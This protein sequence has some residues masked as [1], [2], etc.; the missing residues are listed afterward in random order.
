[1]AAKTEKEIGIKMF[2]E[3]DSAA[4]EAQFQ[5]LIKDLEAS[6][7]GM[8]Q[9]MGA[10]FGGSFRPQQVFDPAQNRLNLARVLSRATELQKGSFT[11]GGIGQAIEDEVSQGLKDVL[12]GPRG[13]E[14]FGKK[15]A[16]DMGDAFDEMLTGDPV[17]QDD[18]LEF[19][20]SYD[21]IR[22]FAS[23]NIGILDE[24]IE[25]IGPIG[26]EIEAAFQTD[27]DNEQFIE[28]ADALDYLGDVSGIKLTPTLQRLTDE[29][30]D[31]GNEFRAVE[32]K[33][34][35]GRIGTEIGGLAKPLAN[36][37]QS[38]AKFARRIGFMA[39]IMS[40]TAQRIV[41]AVKSIGMQIVDLIKKFGS[42]DSAGK[43][44]S[45]ALGKLALG[46][47]ATEERINDLTGAF[48]SLMEHIPAVQGALGLLESAWFQLGAA[49]VEG[50]VDPDEALGPFER[51]AKEIYR[52][53]TDNTLLNAISSAI[54]NFL[55]PIADAL[56]EI[57]QVQIAAFAENLQYVASILGQFAAGVIQGFVDFVNW[58]GK[59]VEHNPELESLAFWLGKILVPVMLLGVPVTLIASA[60]NILGTAIGSLLSPLAKTVGILT[61]ASEGASILSK[62]ITFLQGK[63]LW[64]IPGW[65]L[66]AMAIATVTAYGADL[67]GLFNR[68][69]GPALGRL[70]INL[71]EVAGSL[72]TVWSWF[73]DILGLPIAIVLSTIIRTLTVLV[74]WINY[75]IDA[76]QAFF[77][78]IMD[79]SRRS[80]LH[81]IVD[82][83]QDIYGFIMD[84]IQGVKDLLGLKGLFGRGRGGGDV[85]EEDKGGRDR[86]PPPSDYGPPAEDTG[87]GG[88][89]PP[90]STGTPI[91]A[92]AGSL[93]PPDLQA[94]YAE[95]A[96]ASKAAMLAIEQDRLE[97]SRTSIGTQNVTINVNGAQDPKLVA[98]EVMDHIHR[99]AA[100]DGGVSSSYILNRG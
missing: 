10:A 36:A 4:L 12:V 13:G 47:L 97:E 68:T 66:V 100:L 94:A 34:T 82:V 51:I 83:L 48:L 1:M 44:F 22:E 58:V 72:M 99:E 6:V 98:D 79:D 46:G 39:F 5:R 56:E 92:S 30:N 8:A 65:A 74:E 60:F 80:I 27:L 2:A 87:G 38:I 55:T 52:I 93:M 31:L 29:V 7:Q 61:D 49:I 28:M 24:V 76:W 45:D 9:R 26:E 18:L 40:F 91:F 71:G 67:V 3:L 70:F 15:F 90:P 23:R 69:L 32:P 41:N 54:E 11:M 75:G 64:F 73:D 20:E 19:M 89:T 14:A 86:T 85:E 42:F 95:S 77:G 96:E 50:A 17:A 84:I 53:L 25:G 37:G 43:M 21:E 81:S 88:I 33:S 78:W 57:G 63:V 62:A 16:E 35:I 59:V